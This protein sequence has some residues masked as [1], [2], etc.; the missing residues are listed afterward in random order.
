MSDSLGILRKSLGLSAKQEEI[1]GYLCDTDLRM[2][3]ICAKVGVSRSTMSY[4][5]T[6]LYAK[7]G[8]RS[9]VALIHKW[10]ELLKEQ[11]RSGLIS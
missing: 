1:R 4:H 2:D 7:L 8:V 6:M 10:Q 11:S 9:R 5:R 3:E